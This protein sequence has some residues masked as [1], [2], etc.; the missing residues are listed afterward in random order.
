MREITEVLT[1]PVLKKRYFCLWIASKLM[2]GKKRKQLK[3]KRKKLKMQI[4][5]IRRVLKR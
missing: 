4:K 3:E 1:L 5:S 2:F